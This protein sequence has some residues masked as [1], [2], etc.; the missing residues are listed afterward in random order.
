MEN[1]P[2]KYVQAEILFESDKRALKEKSCGDHYLLLKH[3][4]EQGSILV[5]NFP[6]K[7]FFL[8][9]HRALIA[10]QA[11]QQLLLGYWTIFITFNIQKALQYYRSAQK[12]TSAGN[13]ILIREI[14]MLRLTSFNFKQH[15]E[16]KSKKS[17][18]LMVLRPVL[19]V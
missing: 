7:Y 19:I 1:H 10:Q 3:D 13:G 4:A 15:F 8:I 14:G 11:I 5:T 6:N 18:L 17:L 9:F 16:C 12:Y 2:D